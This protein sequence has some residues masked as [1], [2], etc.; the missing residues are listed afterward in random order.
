MPWLKLRQRNKHWNTTF[1]LWG[2]TNKNQSKNYIADQNYK[3]ISLLF[4]LFLSLQFSKPI[5]KTMLSISVNNAEIHSE[6]TISTSAK[7][8]WT[9]LLSQRKSSEILANQSQ[10]ESP[11]KIAQVTARRAMKIFRFLQHSTLTKSYQ[12]YT[13]NGDLSHQRFWHLQ[14]MASGIKTIFEIK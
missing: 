6:V 11:T 5:F 2:A 4:L 7:M 12:T 1:V 3:P 10:D 8:P 9:A 13:P 14:Q